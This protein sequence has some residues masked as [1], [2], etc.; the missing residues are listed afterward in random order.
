VWWLKTA[1]I[2]ATQR[3]VTANFLVTESAASQAAL[4]VSPWFLDPATSTNS[5]ALA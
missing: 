5:L 4:G 3:I 2:D 1:P